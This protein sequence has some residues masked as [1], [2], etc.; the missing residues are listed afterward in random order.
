MN[1]DEFDRRARVRRQLQVSR[2][3]IPHNGT[4][5]VFQDI[6]DVEEW[7]SLLDYPAFWEAVAPYE[8][9]LQDRDLCDGLI[10]SGKVKPALMLANLKFMAMLELR[11]AFGL[12]HRISQPLSARLPASVH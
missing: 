10:A 3:A 8:L 4:M 7:L 1:E 6:Q 12:K 5:I 9:G 11:T 2:T